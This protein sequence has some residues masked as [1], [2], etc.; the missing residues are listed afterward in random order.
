[1]AKSISVYGIIHLTKSIVP[2]GFRGSIV[3]VQPSCKFDSRKCK[4]LT[5][6]KRRYGTCSHVPYGTVPYL[7]YIVPYRTVLLRLRDGKINVSYEVRFP[8]SNYKL[9][10]TLFTWYFTPKCQ[11]SYEC[12]K[13]ANFT[14]NFCLTL[15]PE[16]SRFEY[17]NGRPR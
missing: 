1:M 13:K 8:K 3:E 4:F 17:R 10:M 11:N 6:V 9:H 2:V 5:P 12:D 14:R 16:V 7:K 15:D